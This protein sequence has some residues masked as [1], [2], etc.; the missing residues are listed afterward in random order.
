M[1][2]SQ[3]N[4][5]KQQLMKWREK[6]PLDTIERWRKAMDYMA[7][8]QRIGSNALIKRRKLTSIPGECL[9][10]VDGEKDKVLIYFHGGGYISGSIHNSLAFASRLALKSRVSVLLAGYRLAPEHPFPAAL[11]DA[12]SA[13]VKVLSSGISGENIA[14]G[15]NSAGGG[16][17]LAT[18]I[19]ARDMGL[20]LPKFSLLISPWVDLT[21]SGSSIKENVKVDPVLTP[22]ALDFAA[23]L[24][25]GSKPASHPQV[26]PLFADLKGL[27]PSFIQ[28]G[29]A[30]LLLDDSIRF[31]TKAR[32]TGI[33]VTLDRWE[34]CPHCF[35][36]LNENIPEVKEGFDNIL[37]FIRQFF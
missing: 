14:I 3:M 23:S 19:K 37:K 33:D 28:V 8:F 1:I 18:M 17:A 4:R 9:S 25:A 34:G 12:L 16:L 22:A 6:H 32:S 11:N 24:Y 10:P 7:T 26:S 36:L 13:Y 29:T 21:N 31:F 20:P 27:P 35:V 2:S 15:G 30:E 5:T